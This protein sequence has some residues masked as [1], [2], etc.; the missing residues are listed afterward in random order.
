MTPADI[1]ICI[2][3]G[4]IIIFLIMLQRKNKCKNCSYCK[5]KDNCMN[6]KNNEN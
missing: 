1:V 4:I 3:L 2:I 6:K 5:K